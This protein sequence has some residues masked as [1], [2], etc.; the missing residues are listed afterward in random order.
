[1]KLFELKTEKDYFTELIK[2]EN[3]SSIE[4]ALDRINKFLLKEDDLLDYDEDDLFYTKDKNGRDYKY[5]YTSSDGQCTFVESLNEF[6]ESHNT[7][8]KWNVFKAIEIK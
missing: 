5:V 7:E 4:E 3:F 6:A 1:M 2:I 8:E